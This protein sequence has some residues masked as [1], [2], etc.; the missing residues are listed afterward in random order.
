[1]K[2][3][4]CNQ[5]PPHPPLPTRQAGFSKGSWTIP[6]FGIFF[7]SLDRQRGARGD[8]GNDCPFN[9]HVFPSATA[10]TSSISQIREPQPDLRKYVK[11]GYRDNLERHEWH[12]S[13]E[14]LVQCHVRR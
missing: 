1:M 12:H 10:G 6:L 9:L 14:D 5:S 11:Q 13:K 2:T 8:F 4:I 3:L 7:L